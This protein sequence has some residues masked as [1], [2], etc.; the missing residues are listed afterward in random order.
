MQ[1]NLDVN[2]C[3]VPKKKKQKKKL[4]KSKINFELCFTANQENSQINCFVGTNLLI[5][6]KKKSLKSTQRQ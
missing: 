2:V 6:Q 4:L 5:S 1:N 3:S